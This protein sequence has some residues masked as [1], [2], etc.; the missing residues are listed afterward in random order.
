MTRGRADTGWRHRRSIASRVLAA[1]VGCYAG[2][3]LASAAL[4]RALVALSLVPRV[5]AVLWTSLGSFALY[6]AG[7]L[8]VFGAA[9]ATRAWVG[10]GCVALA[11]A[12]ILV[13]PLPG[14]G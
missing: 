12:A 7:A 13:L 3:A 9:T 4:A 2:A 8:A 11:S 6:A 5:D 10:L 14:P 1:T